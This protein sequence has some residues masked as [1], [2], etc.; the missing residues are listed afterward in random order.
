MFGPVEISISRFWD[1]Y[2]FIPRTFDMALTGKGGS[3]RKILGVR[4]RSPRE[5]FGKLYSVLGEE[6]EK[7][8]DLTGKGGGQHPCQM[9]AEHN[10]KV[11]IMAFMGVF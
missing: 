1:P 4:G 8:D 2:S 11:L 9:F 5:N 6:F 7:S 10:C 3:A